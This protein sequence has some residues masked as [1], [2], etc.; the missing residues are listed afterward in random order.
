[1]AGKK[2]GKGK[3]GKK[4]KKSKKKIT[5]GNETPDVVVRRLWKHYDRKC[6]ESGTFVSK[7][8]KSAMLSAVENEDLFTK[9]ILML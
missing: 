1:M 6:Q 2:K 3:K 9:V 8:V 7:D 5:I 4:G